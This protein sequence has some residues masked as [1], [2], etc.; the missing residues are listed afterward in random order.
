VICD[1]LVQ[2]VHMIS[3]KVVSSGTQHSNTDSLMGCCMDC[4]KNRG[5]MADAVQEP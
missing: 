1:V 5:L 3:N 4:W 2:L